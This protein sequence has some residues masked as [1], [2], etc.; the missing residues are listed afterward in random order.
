M[1]MAAMHDVV[2]AG[3][4]PAGLAAARAAARGGA[5]VVVLEREAA[6]GIPTRTSGGSFIASLRAL[7]IPQ[8][9]WTPMREVRF[10]GPASEA[11]FTYDD[12]EVC[13]LDVRALYQWLAEEAA[14]AG[15]ELQLR[16]T[17][18]G[19][20]RDGTI[21]E[22][23]ARR[24]GGAGGVASYR[25]RWAVDATGTAAVLAGATGMHPA[26]RRRG[27]GA[28]LDLAA[29]GFPADVCVLAVGEALA[30]SGYAWAFPYRPGRVRLGVGV[31]RP[32]A[33]A[34]PRD[35][36]ERARSL[37]AL[38]PLLEGAQPVEMHAGIIPAEPLRTRIL[39]GGVVCC[40]DSASHASTLVG[41]GIRFAI[42]AGD[43]AGR[44]LA[45]AVRE[46]G[47]APL[48]GFERSWRRRHAR[49]F[50]IAYRINRRLSGFDDAHWD[51]AVGLLARTPTWFATAA[52]STDF[53]PG[54]LVHLAA[55]NPGLA[56]R[57]A[58]A[59]R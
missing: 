44:A 49:D 16:T 43:A 21:L 54:L 3:G 55:T 13:V 28:E 53:R 18:G 17:V 4:G 58:R 19:L 42:A 24:G 36:L 57:F 1:T 56:W 10:V 33:A 6:F 30:P 8:R 59:A 40:G 23:E 26:Y 31:M 41:E 20:R 52:L 46:G 32:D 25:A 11:V 34:D 7:G 50:G 51:R 15:A 14:A 27:V 22:V 37:P 5:R 35:L 48:R 47:D 38:R 39:S 2:V 45:Q 29:P 9:L 12:P